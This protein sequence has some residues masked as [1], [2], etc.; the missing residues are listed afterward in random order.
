MKF[1]NVFISSPSIVLL[2]ILIVR[3]IK[4][5]FFQSFWIFVF[6]FFLVWSLL[7][8]NISL[9]GAAKI[10]TFLL[11]LNVTLIW[12]NEQTDERTN[13]P[14]NV[15]LI[16]KNWTNERR[17]EQTNKRYLYLKERTNGQKLYFNLKE[18]TNKQTNQRTL[19]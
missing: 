14:K 15:T 3:L 8:R 6:C 16:W 7:W 10:L 19:L 5:L 13:E 9:G 2:Q 1:W 18:H 4:I 11:K 12:K 17:N